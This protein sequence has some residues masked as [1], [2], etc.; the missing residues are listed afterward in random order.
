MASYYIMDFGDYSEAAHPCLSALSN[1]DFLRV[2]VAVPEHLKFTSLFE[3]YGCPWILDK[4]PFFVHSTQWSAPARLPSCSVDGK[5]L[6]QIM[7]TIALA[8]WPSEF[9]IGIFRRYYRKYKNPMLALL[10]AEEE[11]GYSGHSFFA[12]LLEESPTTRLLSVLRPSLYK[13]RIINSSADVKF[14]DDRST[15]LIAGSIRSS[16]G[17]RSALSLYDYLVSQEKLNEFLDGTA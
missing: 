16:M 11:I 8:R 12:L 15:S 13:E 17:Y 14:L 7:N 5:N 1:C 6:Y 4:H 2:G 10:F 9:D 3:E